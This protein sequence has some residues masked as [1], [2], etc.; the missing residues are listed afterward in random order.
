[1]KENKEKC[2]C[3]EMTCSEYVIKDGC[4]H[5]LDCG[6]N[7]KCRLCGLLNKGIE[8]PPKDSNVP[9]WEKDLSEWL[10]GCELYI[11]NPYEPYPANVDKFLR[12]FIYRIIASETAKERLRAVEIIHKIFMDT[13]NIKVMDALEHAQKEIL[14]SNSN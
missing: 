8:L 12:S 1:M 4:I 14:R 10:H 3:T 9:K 11:I 2:D 7:G 13:T 5:S 6:K